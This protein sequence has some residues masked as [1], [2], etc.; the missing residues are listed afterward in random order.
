M[1]ENST[2]SGVAHPPEPEAWQCQGGNVGPAG[3][4]KAGNGGLTGGVP[5]VGQDVRFVHEN[6][7]GEITT[8]GVA[9]SLTSGGGKPGQGYP[10]IMMPKVEP[11]PPAGGLTVRRLTPTE[12]L[13]LQSM[14]EDWMDVDPPLSDNAKYRCIGNGGVSNVLKWIASRLKKALEKDGRESAE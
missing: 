12:C 7:R 6:V 9:N 1:I 11:T 14:P 13:R 4:L 5:F 8:P 2:T 10:C 3:T